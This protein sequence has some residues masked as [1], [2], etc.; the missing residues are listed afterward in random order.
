MFKYGGDYVENFCGGVLVS[1]RHV[2]TAAHCFSSVEEREWRSGKVDVRIGQTDLDKAEDTL[3]SADILKVTV[4]TKQNDDNA[5]LCL[6]R[7]I[8]T[9]RRDLPVL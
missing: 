6:L 1:R 5:T 8:P 4:S 7:F 2:L 9:I 3:A